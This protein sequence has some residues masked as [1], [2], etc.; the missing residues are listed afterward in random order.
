MVELFKAASKG[1]LERLKKLLT[2]GI[3]VNAKSDFY[4][5]TA[6]HDAAAEGHLAVV[7]F[8]IKKGTPQPHASAL[9][10]CR[11]YRSAAPRR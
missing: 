6:L 5:R 4:G 9:P 10:Q 7:D 11:A 3:D 2:S 1:D 8:L